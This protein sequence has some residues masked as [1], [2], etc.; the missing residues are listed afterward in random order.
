M[1]VK[2][3]KGQA[4]FVALRL[5]K[6]SFLIAGAAISKRRMLTPEACSSVMEKPRDIAKRIKQLARRDMATSLGEIR[7]N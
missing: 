1:S 5:L 6:G 7:A 2:C 3:H 4:V